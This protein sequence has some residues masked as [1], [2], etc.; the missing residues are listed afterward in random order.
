M[1]FRLKQ[2]FAHLTDDDLPIVEGDDVELVG[3]PQKKLPFGQTE[4][5]LY[6][7]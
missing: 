2:E 3:Q 5:A 6:V 4:G 7:S 1:V